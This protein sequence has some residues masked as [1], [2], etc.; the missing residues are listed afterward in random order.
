MAEP[1]MVTRSRTGPAARVQRGDTIWLISQLRSP[2]GSFR[3]PWSKIAAASRQHLIVPCANLIRTLKL[4][5][6]NFVRCV[7]RPR[8]SRADVTL[9]TP[10]ADFE[11][12]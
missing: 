12:P 3:P 8:R 4:K 2:W 5:T 9:D 7:S 1:A 6:T 11:A 10:A